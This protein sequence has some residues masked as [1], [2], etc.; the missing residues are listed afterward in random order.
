MSGTK[1]ENIKQG[2]KVKVV[3]KQDQR[4]GKLTEGVVS[5]IL[6]NSSTHPHGIKVMLTSGIVGR[7]K[8]ILD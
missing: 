7:V 8:E 4:S 3:Q 1:R 5:K 6:T 2:T